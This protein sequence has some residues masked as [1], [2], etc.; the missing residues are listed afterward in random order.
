MFSSA[1]AFYKNNSIATKEKL[2]EVL[3]KN[4]SKTESIE[5]LSYKDL[6]SLQKAID[7]SNNKGSGNNQIDPS[8]YLSPYRRMTAMED[9]LKALNAD[10][11]SEI[12]IN[13][14]EK[15]KDQNNNYHLRIDAYREIRFTFD[16]QLQE[17]FAKIIE[18][19]VKLDELEK[20]RK[21]M[22]KKN[23]EE[24]R[25]LNEKLKK[26]TFQA[27]M[28]DMKNG[29]NQIEALQEQ[30]EKSI[31]LVDLQ[32]IEFET[33][34]KGYS[35]NFKAIVKQYS[36]FMKSPA[37]SIDS[38]LEAVKSGDKNSLQSDKD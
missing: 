12:L 36:D 32:K 29:I 8:F 34:L 16:K 4:F 2:E 19:E 7:I 6:K 22:L 17:V 37:S 27:R 9:A 13:S 23:E 26:Q 20:Q 31:Q 15:A 24:L 3:H 30:H 21:E 11:A 28:F 14:F 33:T 5:K 10:G 1:K 38:Y 18:F 35:E 25:K